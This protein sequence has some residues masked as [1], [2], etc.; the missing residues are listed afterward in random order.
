M[1]NMLPLI[2]ACALPVGVAVTELPA[3][4]AR[5]APRL[6]PMLLAALLALLALPP[7]A[8]SL[9]YVGRQAAGDSRVQLLAW[10]DAEVPPGA[11]VAAE[12]KAVP[13]PS[14]ARWVD[15]PSLPAHDLAWYRAQGFA[16]LVGS[17]K[18]WGQLAPPASYGPLLEREVAAFGPLER[19]EMLGPRLVVI[20]TGL[21]ANDAALSLDGDVRVGAARLAGV[22]LGDPSAGGEPP[23][24][25]PTREFRAGGV[26]GIRSFW[27][28]RE[29]FDRDYLIFVHLIDANGGRPTQRDAA[30][31]QGRFPTSSWRPGSLVVDANDVYLPPGMPPGEYRVVMGMYDPAT[32]ARP[33]AT[34]DGVPLPDG[35]VEVATIRV[36][37]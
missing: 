18:R 17:S 31:W 29:P 30:P 1:Q 19:E 10:L 12:L 2:V 21:Q 25:R 32:G 28:P 16:Y 26:L 9:A 3:L 27:E 37:E 36:V 6:R 11:R 23:M 34:R 14:E 13:G 33:P 35:Q 15:V 4:L 22:T 20:D 7:L 8:G 5:R 24:L